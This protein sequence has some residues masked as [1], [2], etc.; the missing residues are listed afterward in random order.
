MAYER[1]QLCADQSSAYLPLHSLQARKSRN[2][3]AH[4]IFE[5]LV[6]N[7]LSS[8]IVVELSMTN[9]LTPRRVILEHIE[10]GIS[11]RLACNALV[12]AQGLYG[13]FTEE[14]GH[15]RRLRLTRN[16]DNA[17]LAHD[18]RFEQRIPSCCQY[19]IGMSHQS[20][21]RWGGS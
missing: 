8:M 9:R 1:T 10:Y 5:H 19:N 6:C 7:A 3:M 17:W 12:P 13:P 21:Q 20:I 15:G 18:Q 2:S 11:N 14:F 16:R 4:L